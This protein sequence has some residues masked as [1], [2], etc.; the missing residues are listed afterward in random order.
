M[1]TTIAPAPRVAEAIGAPAILLIG[2]SGGGKTYSLT[3]LLE[4]G[5]ELFVFVTE[6]NG[7]ETLI[8]T[9]VKKN[10]PVDRIHYMVIS[11]T[12]SGFDV[13]SQL[14]KTVSTSSFDGLSKLPPSAGRQ[15]AKFHALLSGMANFVDERTGEV[16]G[17]I[18]TFGPDRAVVVDSL[19]GLNIMA[20]DLVIG[21]KPTA[22]QGEWG[23]AMNVLEKLLNK[24]CGDLK[25]FFVLTAH[26]ER[27]Q[28]EI[29]G[30]SK[31]MVGILGRKLAPKVPRFFSEVVLAYRS[32]RD[33]YWSTIESTTDL[34]SRSL[35]LSDKIPPTF[36]P[37][38]D[39]YRAR[40]KALSP[41]FPPAKET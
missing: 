16:F 27:E 30:G 3:T 11:P 18:D 8:D 26:I 33:Y 32:T 31:N 17:S 28:D 23:V 10:L 40:L 1:T 21:S 2:G 35:P 39:A 24:L 14:A 38:V 5:L 15:D 12:R 34:K 37:I 36:K 7:L 19:S 4:A 41:T 13:L 22:H 29:T 6:P 20:M 9:A 25:C